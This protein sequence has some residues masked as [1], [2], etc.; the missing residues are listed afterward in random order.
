MDSISQVTTEI[1]KLLEKI[2]KTSNNK[3]ILYSRLSIARQTQ[4]EKIYNYFVVEKDINKSDLK[5]ED[6]SPI[7]NI[8]SALS[9]IVALIN[10]DSIVS[11]AAF[12]SLVESA[13]SSFLEIKNS[14][15]GLGTLLETKIRQENT[16]NKLD[17]PFLSDEDFDRW[18]LMN[19]AKDPSELKK[20]ISDYNHYKKQI[21]KLNKELEKNVD[22]FKQNIDDNNKNI[23]D[24]LEA[25]SDKYNRE[26]DALNRRFNN[27]SIKMYEEELAKYFLDE[28]DDLKG[29]F[30]IRYC[31]I[32][33]ILFILFI[34]YSECKLYWFLLLCLIYHSVYCGIESVLEKC[35]FE[36]S[37]KKDRV[38]GY[39]TQYW[40][41]LTAT[42][43][44]MSALFL[45]AV[46]VCFMMIDK[47]TSFRDLL[48]FTGIYFVLVWFTWFASKQYSYT[49]QVCDEYEYK[50]AL[51]KTYV[52]FRDEAR[53][54]ITMKNVDTSI[55]IALLDSVI[56]NVASSPIQCVKSDV[57]TPLSEAVKALKGIGNIQDNK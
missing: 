47:A 1:K 25:I 42:I 57:H 39:F 18:L 8:R 49:K 20:I 32:L 15:V 41:W 19:I 37:L 45:A 56:K 46:F 52:S 17:E 2:Y 5:G 26:I 54:L 40:C 16:Q 35:S 36:Y 53:Q 23:T 31:L 51:S 22:K 44:G 3:E 27:L 13:Y 14:K 55:M 10:I 11:N 43:F 21:D 50:Y 33:F 4:L 6:Y 7:C 12:N 48:P 24:S 28:H 34:V 29:D 38:K 9:D 30:D